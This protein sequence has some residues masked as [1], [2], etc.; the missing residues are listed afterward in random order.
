MP[1]NM[2]VPEVEAAIAQVLA[3]EREALAAVEAARAEGGP[4]ILQCVSQID[5]IDARRDRTHFHGFGQSDNGSD[6]S[7]FAAAFTDG[8]GIETRADLDAIERR[9]AKISE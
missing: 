6:E 9:A 2:P 4:G 3:A 8:F 1:Q 7:D 5:C